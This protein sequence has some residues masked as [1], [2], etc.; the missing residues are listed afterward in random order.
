MDQSIPLLSSPL[1]SVVV[2]RTPTHPT[3]L[4]SPHSTTSNSPLDVSPTPTESIDLST[5]P[6]PQPPK[7]LN[8]NHNHP[9]KPKPIPKLNLPTPTPKTHTIPNPTPPLQTLK[10]IGFLSSKSRKGLEDI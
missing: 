5:H 3:H 7:N 9:I 1:P 4:I 8:L 10:M 2:K 6:I